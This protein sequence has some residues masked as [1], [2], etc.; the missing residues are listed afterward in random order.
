MA[1]ELPLILVVEDDPQV[2]VGLERLAR[3]LP[4]RL[5][6]VESAEAAWPVLEAQRPMALLSDYR[7]PGSDGLTLLERAQARFPGLRCMLHTGEAVRRT[8]IPLDFPVVPKPCAVEELQE[9]LLS[10]VSPEGP[11]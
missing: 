11:R 2:V 5:V 1:T 7:L 8:S 3:R 6:F 10:L 9:V 4:L